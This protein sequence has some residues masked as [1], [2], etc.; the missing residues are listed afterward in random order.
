VPTVRAAT[1]A[2][3]PAIADYLAQHLRG[4]GG[5]ERYR[6]FFAYAWLADRD[7]PDLGMLVEDAGRVRGFIGAI[8]AHRVIRG[9][10]RALCNLNCW[11]V[12]EEVRMH[13]L[14]ML[15]KL[16]DRREYDFTCVSPSDRVTELLR[17][18][19]FETLDEGKLLFVPTSGV[20][21]DPRRWRVRVY[22][23]RRGI[24]AHLDDEQRRVFA[25]HAPYRL[26]Q[27]V[28]ERG[29]RACYVVMARR[30]RG[31]RVF[32]D[33]LHVSDPALF[34]ETIGLL[35]PRVA[36]ALGTPLVGLDRRFA[37]AR[38]PA[39]TIAYDKLRKPLYRSATL[40]PTDLDALYTEF[41]PMYG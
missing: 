10:R 14:V 34:V 19:K 20:P 2:D 4:E 40:A 5:A 33:V 18:F 35:A 28:I 37:G 8:Y 21:L 22:D 1:P 9:E 31:V 36:L 17:F 29:D 41:V 16:L 32:A 38:R 13:S 23:A 30:G 7:K 27:W 39:R 12:D 6:R 25:D 26:A 24:E 3:L 15:K 11:R